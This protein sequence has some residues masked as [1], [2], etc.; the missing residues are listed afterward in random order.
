MKNHIV[1]AYYNENLNWLC[2]ININIFDIFIYNKSGIQLKNFD[3][4]KI[5]PLEN[6]GRESHTY[7]YHIIENY[8][9]L[10]EYCIFLQGEPFYHSIPNLIEHINQLNFSITDFFYYSKD[11]LSLRFEG[12]YLKES[13]LLNNSI[14]NNKHAPTSAIIITLLELFPELDKNH[15]YTFF[16]TGA[17]FSVH[18][19]TISRNSLEFY[20]KCMDILKKSKNPKNPDEGHGFERLWNYIFNHDL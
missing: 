19:K 2:N 15:F 1:V 6:I 10:P 3:F 5:I 9:C 8:D 17:L 4:C 13:G 20:E 14:W 18:R 12:V 16:G 11:C 7:L